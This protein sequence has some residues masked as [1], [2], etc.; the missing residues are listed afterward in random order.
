MVRA[1]AITFAVIFV[2]ALIFTIALM[3]LPGWVV[4]YG[5]FCLIAVVLAFASAVA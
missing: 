4:L 5:T 3:T 1:L 2:V